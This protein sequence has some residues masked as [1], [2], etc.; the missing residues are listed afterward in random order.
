MKNLGLSDAQVTRL[1]EQLGR[2]A[3]RVLTTIQSDATLDHEQDTTQPALQNR[4][5]HLALAKHL[6]RA[7]AA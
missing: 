3:D 6:T 5:Q 7:A 4:V 2:G 1:S